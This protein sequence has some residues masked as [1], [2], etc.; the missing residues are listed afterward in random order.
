MLSSWVCAICFWLPIVLFIVNHDPICFSLLVFWDSAFHD[1]IAYFSQFSLPVDSLLHC[2]FLI[3][4]SLLFYLAH[5]SIKPIY[6]YSPVNV[7]GDRFRVLAR[8]VLVTIVFCELNSMRFSYPILVPTSND[9]GICRLILLF[10]FFPFAFFKVG[11]FKFL[12]FLCSLSLIETHY[13][14]TLGLLVYCAPDYVL[15]RSD[16]FSSS[17]SN[18]LNFPF[19]LFG[20]SGMVILHTYAFPSYYLSLSLV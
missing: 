6:S 19:Y 14:S 3:S 11:R 9:F 1:L 17:P 8:L 4:S 16:Q 15:R 7:F 18:R 13:Y 20:P 10:F 12:R 2:N 5:L